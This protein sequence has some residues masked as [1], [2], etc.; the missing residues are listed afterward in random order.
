MLTS[1]DTNVKI[2]D[3]QKEMS[4]ILNKFEHKEPSI[5]QLAEHLG[6]NADEQKMIKLFWEPAFNKG[7]IYLSD[8]II[9]DQLTKEKGKDSLTN[10]Y[11]QVFL[12]DDYVENI[13]YKKITKDDDLVKMHNE[14]LCS[15]NFATQKDNRGGVNKKY[16][17]ITE[18]TYEKLLI[19][20]KIRKLKNIKYDEK[21]VSNKLSDQ[22]D[23]KREVTLKCGKRIDILSNTEIIEVKSYKSRLSAIGQILY[24]SKCYPDKQKRIHLF[25][26]NNKTDLRFQTICDEL[27]IIVTYE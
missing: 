15:L 9:L 24:Y 19:S 22:L 16:Y 3:D 11:K 5:Q 27:C 20:G 10:F 2:S 21:K 1:I 17:A 23:G 8:E 25:D 6:F 18:K 26:H 14:F 4:L 13:D 12:S 7:W